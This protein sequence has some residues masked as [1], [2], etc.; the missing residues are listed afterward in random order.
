MLNSLQE[1]RDHRFMIDY[2]TYQ[3]LH[4]YR[5]IFKNQSMDKTNESVNMDGPP[6]DDFLVLL[7]PRIHAFDLTGKTWSKGR[8]P[9]SNIIRLLG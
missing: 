2:K 7:P 3:T 5:S 8:T 1:T 9:N 6:D 4:P